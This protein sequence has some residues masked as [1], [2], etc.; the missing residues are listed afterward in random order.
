MIG[1]IR[2][3]IISEFNGANLPHSIDWIGGDDNS[4]SAMWEE[5]RKAVSRVDPVLNY[6]CN[7]NKPAQ[8]F[9]GN[10]CS[11]YF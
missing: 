10:S 5:R 8:S 3:M 7:I 11:H 2:S 1:E 6:P 9:Y 4:L